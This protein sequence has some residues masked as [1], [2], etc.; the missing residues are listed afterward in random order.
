MMNT[1]ATE[2][3]LIKQILSSAIDDEY[4]S[5]RIYSHQTNYK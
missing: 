2:Y 3:T 4:A 5:H 1:L